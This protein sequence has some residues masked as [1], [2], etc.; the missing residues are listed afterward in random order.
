MR[1]RHSRSEKN[2]WRLKEILSILVAENAAYDMTPEKLRRILEKLGPTFVKIGQMISMREDL[3]PGAYCRELSLLR[4][5]VQPLPYAMVKEVLLSELGEEKLSRFSR[6]DPTPL[7]SASIAQ[8]HRAYLLPNQRPVVVKVQRPHIDT[9]MHEDLRLLGKAAKMLNITHFAGNIDFSLMVQEMQRVTDEELDFLAEAHH[10][11]RFA[12]LNADLVYI[13]CPAVEWEFCTPRVLVMEYIDGVRIDDTQQLEAL[14]YDMEEIGT[15]LAE[16]YSKQVMDD[17]FFHADPHPGNLFIRDGKIIWMDMGMMG[18][19][20]QRDRLMLRKAIQGVINHDI[21][22]VKEVVLSMGSPRGQINHSRLYNDID[23]LMSRYAS[24]DLQEMNLGGLLREVMEV[25]RAHSI[26]MPS[27]ITMLMR[28]I[29]TIEGVVADCAPSISF[30]RVVGAH[31]SSSLFQEIDVKKAARYVGR[32]LLYSSEHLLELPSKISELTGMM[33]KGQSKVNLEIVGSEEPL[34][35]IN[36]MVNNI[37]LAVIAA[38]LFLG[39]AILCTTQV[40]PLVFG[41]PL[42]GALGFFASAL[43]GGYVVFQVI[44]HRRK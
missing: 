11:D 6:I 35:R 24:L 34:R 7:G 4:S 5:Q 41:I 10:M 2:P 14:G 44:F 20:T 30:I 37:I 31:M 19:L 12:Q 18:T 42:L 43:V 23:M 25:A 13:G 36:G 33:I 21:G 3:L 15:K 9:L 27:G 26:M 8:V 17:A 16:N 40:K 28:G 39:S 1:I 22:A 38:S 29:L 32:T